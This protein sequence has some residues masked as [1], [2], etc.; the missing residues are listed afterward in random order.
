MAGTT[1]VIS[2]FGRCLAMSAQTNWK[3]LPISSNEQK[4]LSSLRRRTDVVIKP[5]DKGS[6]TVVMSKDDYL[7]RVMHHLDNIQ[8]YEK[9]TDNPTEHFSEEITSLL[10]KM[11]EKRVLEKE[12]FCFLQPQ[13]VRISRFYILW[14]MCINCCANAH[15]ALYS[16]YTYML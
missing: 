13:N 12:T 7:T 15:D 1:L 10:E 14:S 3:G 8:L 16:H 9:W 2:V 6:A 4:A 5:D 11:K